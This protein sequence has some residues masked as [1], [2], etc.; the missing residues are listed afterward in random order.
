M[1]TFIVYTLRIILSQLCHKIF[2]K[3]RLYFLNAAREATLLIALIFN[4]EA[5]DLDRKAIIF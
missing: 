2:H 5:K 1:D 4:G 3:E